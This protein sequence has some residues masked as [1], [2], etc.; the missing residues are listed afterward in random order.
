MGPLL[1]VPY[2]LHNRYLDATPAL[3]EL[4]A[5]ILSRFS[6][7]YL[8]DNLVFARTYFFN[9]GPNI[10]NSIWLTAMG[11]VSFFGLAVVGL[12]RHLRWTEPKYLSKAVS[13]VMALMAN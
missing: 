5:G 2:A 4:R 8:A 9:L 1:L 13:Y 7:D 12:R 6:L 3:W 10:L 11:L